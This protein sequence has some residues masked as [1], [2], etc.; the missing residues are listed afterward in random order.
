VPT[1]VKALFR[2][3][4][5]AGRGRPSRTAVVRRDGSWFGGAS[6]G[7]ALPADPNV[8][9]EADLRRYV[10]ALERTGSSGRTPGT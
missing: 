8:L 9:T 6:Q 4:S 3:G 10:A 7:P 5:P 2:A 1:T